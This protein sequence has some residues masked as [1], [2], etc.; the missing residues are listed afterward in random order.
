MIGAK[1]DSL[2][3]VGDE[4][5]LDH[6]I[7]G[8][9]AKALTLEASLLLASASRDINTRRLWS[10]LSSVLLETPS[11]VSLEADSRPQTLFLPFGADS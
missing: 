3:Q 7:Y 1:A 2:T 6:L 5:V 4:P 11:E 8:L 10:F 9:R